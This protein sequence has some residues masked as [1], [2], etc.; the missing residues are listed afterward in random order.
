MEVTLSNSSSTGRMESLAGPDTQ[1]LDFQLPAPFV[2]VTGWY[3][4]RNSAERI[5][6][7]PGQSGNNIMNNLQKGERSD[8]KIFIIATAKQ[9]PF[10]RSLNYIGIE[11]MFN[12]INQCSPVLRKTIA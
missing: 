5:I 6:I 1:V 3:V 2:T 12:N 10:C 4:Q 7:N 9:N 8:S 11:P